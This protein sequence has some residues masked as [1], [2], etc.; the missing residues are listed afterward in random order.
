MSCETKQIKFNSKQWK[1]IDG[2]YNHRDQM[3][4][5]LM[6]NVLFIGMKNKEVEKLLGKPNEIKFNNKATYE[7]YYDFH[8]E[9]RRVLKIYFSKDSTISKFCKSVYRSK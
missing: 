7:I 9:E 1:Y 2:T 4:N 5:D 6:D 8:R 3:V